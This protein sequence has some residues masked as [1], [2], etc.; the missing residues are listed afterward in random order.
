MIRRAVT[1]CACNYHVSHK[2]TSTWQSEQNESNKRLCGTN[3]TDKGVDKLNS[4]EYPRAK[5][6]KPRKENDKAPRK[7][8]LTSKCVNLRHD[9]T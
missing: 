5:N 8:H 9:E 6:S 2:H 7:T 4:V 3:L 1:A